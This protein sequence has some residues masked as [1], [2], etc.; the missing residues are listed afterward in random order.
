MAAQTRAQKDTLSDSLINKIESERIS[1]FTVGNSLVMFNRFILQDLP[2][3]GSPSLL[4][5][6]HTDALDKLIDKR[7]RYELSI[8]KIVGYASRIGE[9]IN[10]LSLSQQRAQAV[11]NYLEFVYNND[12]TM[13]DQF[14]FA[15]ARIV[16]KG[17]SDLP[18]PSDA[19]IDNPLNRRVEIVYKLIYYF[20]E[21]EGG[22]LPTS[23][24]WKIDFGPAASAGEIPLGVVSI[25]GTFGAGTLTMLPDPEVNQPNSITRSMTFEQLGI[26]LGFLS[27]LKKLKFLQKIPGVKRLFELLDSVPSGNYVKTEAVLKSIGFSADFISIGGE[28][29]TPE[30]LTFDEMRAMHFATVSGSISILGKGEGNILVLYSDYFLTGTVIFGLGQNL[31]VPDVALQFVPIGRINLGSG[32]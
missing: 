2:F 5:S 7:F 28:F 3:N 14:I 21:P 8:R 32:S 16:A 19:F 30:A 9:P 18:F 13:H 4:T 27:K 24:F 6:T 17:E 15:D 20:P 31:A 29:M 10:N 23:K 12:A 1:H 25:G 26:S 22:F 11:Y